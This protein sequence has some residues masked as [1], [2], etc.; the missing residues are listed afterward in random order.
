MFY[1]AGIVTDRGQRRSVA[2]TCCLILAATV[3]LIPLAG[4]AA[5]LT[6]TALALGFGNGIGSGIVN[7]IG[8]DL[9][10]AIGRPVFLGIWAEIADTGSA[11][12]PMLLSLVA[13]IST[14]TIGIGAIGAVGAVGGVMLWKWVPRRTPTGEEEHATTVDEPSPETSR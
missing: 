10:P 6:V 2:A 4:T 9:S 3:A 12:G 5:W 8:A 13:A 7:T 11:L 14:A 1:P